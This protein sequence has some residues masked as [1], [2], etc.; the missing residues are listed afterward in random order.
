MF[1]DRA[2][3]VETSVGDRCFQPCISNPH[4][5]QQDLLD[6]FRVL[7]ELNDCGVL[8]HEEGKVVYGNTMAAQLLGYDCGFSLVG[9]FL[10]DHVDPAFEAQLLR[11]SRE[12]LGSDKITPAIDY[13]LRNLDQEPVSVEIK[14]QV[15]TWN[16][17]KA[18]LSILK[19]VTVRNFK[20]GAL[21]TLTRV[22]EEMPD[23]VVIADPELKVEYVNPCFEE[24]FGRN[25]EEFKGS[26]MNFF[27]RSALNTE[28][29]IELWSSLAENSN[30]KGQVCFQGTAQNNLWVKL[31]ASPVFE[32]VGEI[33]YFVFTMKDVTELK[34]TENKLRQ[35]LEDAA[36][37]SKAKS[38]FL[39]NMSH[40]LRTP[41]NAVI[42]FSSL[43]KDPQIKFASAT[44]EEYAE[45]IHA[46]GQNLL[47]LIND[48][49]D[50]TRMEVNELELIE[51]R[52]E[53]LSYLRD[54]VASLENQ[55]CCGQVN[56]A[57]DCQEVMILADKRRFRQSVKKLIENGLKFSSGR[58]VDVVVST[59]GA[60]QISIKDSGIG[61]SGETIALAMAPFGQAEKNSYAKNYNG[62]GLGLPIARKLL[63]MHGGSLTIESELLKGTEVK[64]Q[65][66]EKRLVG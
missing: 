23:A 6:H 65:L 37:A 44:V 1:F 50:L 51:E 14:S 17:K 15:I 18:V 9:V 30:W 33:S 48:L 11:R 3:V 62:A 12:V 47:E 4:S 5:D 7:A 35:A 39:A 49:L 60:L 45:Y 61:M 34:T 54:L 16:K 41:L 36:A 10:K 21:R 56:L 57:A 46:G 53:L 55:P 22:V 64:L 29:A 43:L 8:I 20:N 24:M 19:D 28:D 66:P 25:L 13:V 32:K 27:L 2:E 63:E 59:Q 42:G 40:E 26:G 31:S 58:D 52:F 38:N